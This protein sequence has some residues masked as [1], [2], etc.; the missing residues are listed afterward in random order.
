VESLSVKRSESRTMGVCC[1]QGY[2]LDFTVPHG[3]K[4]NT[5]AL[6][7]TKLPMVALVQD[8]EIM[9][10]YRVAPGTSI[11]QV[12]VPTL[13][14]TRVRVP[15]RPL[16]TECVHPHELWPRR[17]G[18]G[19]EPH[20]SFPFPLQS[21]RVSVSITTLNVKFSDVV[22]LRAKSVGS[23]RPSLTR[24]LRRSLGPLH[25]LSTSLKLPLSLL[26]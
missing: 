8:Q 22:K 19:E 1:V 12:G 25:W 11:P 16:A 24:P 2:N 18:V 10:K 23:R 14:L 7:T 26:T 20:P 4:S 17:V 3:M 9:L 21:R 5:M 13:A 15:H 6:V